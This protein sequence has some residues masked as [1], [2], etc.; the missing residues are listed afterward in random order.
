MTKDINSP[1]S[2]EMEWM[3]YRVTK[4]IQLA[5]RQEQMITALKQDVVLHLF[6]RSG[7]EGMIPV[8]CDSAEKWRTMK[9]ESPEKLTFSLK[10]AMFKQLL[11]SLHQRLTETAKDAEAMAKAK[12]LNWVDDQ[13]QWKHLKWNNTTQALEVDSTLRPIPTSDLLAQLVNVRKAVTEES[14]LRFK[15]VRKLTPEVT[16][17]WIQFQ[18]IISMRQ[19][20]GALWS[21]LTQWIGQAAWHTLG[22][23]LRKD[24]PAYDNL[25]RL[26]YG[27]FPLPV[28]AL[29]ML[30]K[31]DRV[32]A[33][34]ASSALKVLKLLPW[35]VLLQA[36][37]NVHQQ[38]DAAEL[39]TYLLPR[40]G[41][42]GMHGCWEARNYAV[43]GVTTLDSGPLG[44]PIAIVPNEG[45][46]IHL[47]QSVEG[48]CAQTTAKYA[49]TRAARILCLQLL[50]YRNLEGT[51]ARDGRALVGFSDGIWMPVFTDAHNMQVRWI[52]YQVT[53]AQLHFGDAPTSGHYR[54]L[55]YGQKGFAACRYWITDDNHVAQ[56]AEQSHYADAM[57]LL[58]LRQDDCNGTTQ[59]P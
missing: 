24:R 12:S 7:P 58:W 49:M 30:C 41:D 16:S 46:V 33:P 35:S 28:S 10:L 51:I 44:Q 32:S 34:A 15:S 27:T 38:H 55:L 11:I 25:V 21:T 29:S 14:L 8:L 6:I 4:L 20:G 54:T 48:W 9:E 31:S 18:I 26:H 17:D 23:R 53:A 22:C 56:P 1:T 57:Y 43:H 13:N 3:E 37:N 5:L 42:M 59:S 36:W 39:T 40:F 2:P 45:D 19:E 52:R 47:Q 50:R